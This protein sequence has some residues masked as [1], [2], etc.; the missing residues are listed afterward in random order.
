MSAVPEKIA[1]CCEM[2]LTTIRFAEEFC[3]QNHR[4]K[5]GDRLVCSGC[6]RGFVGSDELVA[7]VEAADAA[8]VREQGWKW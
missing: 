1:P 2:V 8:W 3:A 7:K 6:G 4:A 5:D